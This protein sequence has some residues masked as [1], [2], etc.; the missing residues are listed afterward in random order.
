LARYLNF[1]AFF[2]PCHTKGELLLLAA[3]D[4]V[5]VAH[6]E[7]LKRQHAVREDALGQGEEGNGVLHV[8][9]GFCQHA[10]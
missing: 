5:K 7:N 2:N 3:F 10:Q 9:N 1:A 8:L 4:E 6:F